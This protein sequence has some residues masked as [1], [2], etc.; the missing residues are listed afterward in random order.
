M[1]RVFGVESNISRRRKRK[2]PRETEYKAINRFGGSFT[3]VSAAVVVVVVV[4]VVATTDRE[5]SGGW[6]R[7]L[8]GNRTV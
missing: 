5:R 1:V 6:G 3:V 8:Q 2:R 4:V 7:L